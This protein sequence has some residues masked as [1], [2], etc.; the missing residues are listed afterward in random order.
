[1]V[2]CLWLGI[3][4]SVVFAGLRVLFISAVVFAVESDD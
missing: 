1:M 4:L 2:R 3:C